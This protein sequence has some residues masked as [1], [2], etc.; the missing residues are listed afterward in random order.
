MTKRQGLVVDEPP[1]QQQQQRTTTE[2]LSSTKPRKEEE[3]QLTVLRFLHASA[4]AAHHPIPGGDEDGRISEEAPARLSP[5][6]ES[7]LVR[8]AISKLS[9]RSNEH[10]ETAEVVID[11]PATPR[12]PGGQQEELGSRRGLLLREVS[13]VHDD[14]PYSNDSPES[15]GHANVVDIDTDFDTDTSSTGSDET[16]NVFWSSGG[17]E[18]AGV[19]QRPTRAASVASTCGSQV[20]PPPPAPRSPP[21]C[22][23]TARRHPNAEETFCRDDEGRRS[24]PSPSAM[25]RKSRNTSPVGAEYLKG[26][27][28]AALG[29]R[30]RTPTFSSQHGE[31][32][33][34]PMQAS[35]TMLVDED[36]PTAV[37][38]GK[39]SKPGPPLAG[40]IAGEAASRDGDETPRGEEIDSVGPGRTRE[41]GGALDQPTPRLSQ[42]IH[43]TPHHPCT[44]STSEADV[45]AAWEGD[46]R[47]SERAGGTQEPP[48]EP[49]RAVGREARFPTPP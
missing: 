22:Y 12:A 19:A 41:S 15:A 33:S 5:E 9:D 7:T 47:V 27:A 8:R 2:V 42:G 44:R 13:F 30:G 46:A 1:T 11:R 36:A 16:A 40:A 38:D 3:Q 25:L 6:Q 10:S 21:P 29:K 39:W 34:R 23:E 49:P 48:A 20:D 24:K 35:E 26:A 37:V 17:V 43:H 31:K 32:G 45:V 18:I 4:E 14:A 28:A